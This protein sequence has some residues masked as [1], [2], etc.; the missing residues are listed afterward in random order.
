MDSGSGCT[1]PHSAAGDYT[2]RVVGDHVARV[3]GG[4]GLGLGLADDCTE[5][6][7]SIE[8]FMQNIQTQE[9]WILLRK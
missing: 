2:A 9:H 6:P 3:V 7:A 1:G 5:E 4:L 8:R